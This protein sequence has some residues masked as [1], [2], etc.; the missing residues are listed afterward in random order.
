LLKR[1]IK[2]AYVNVSPSHLIRYVD[3]RVFAFNN[4]K[5]S[6]FDRFAVALTGVA[7]RRLTYGDLTGK[8]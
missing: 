6:D 4:R 3:E 7:N 5:D 1:S 2:G 8:A